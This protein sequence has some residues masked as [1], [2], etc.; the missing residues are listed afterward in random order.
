MNPL[1][2]IAIYMGAFWGSVTLL[3]TFNPL[4]S[5]GVGVVIGAVSLIGL[6]AAGV[7]RK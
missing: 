1:L 7:L 4:F 6:C 2:K 5:L 3:L